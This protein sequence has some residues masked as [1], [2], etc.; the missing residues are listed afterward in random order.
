[1]EIRKIIEK[2]E[3]VKVAVYGDFCLD[4]YW[5]LDPK[6]SE[7]SVETGLR[8]DSV[9]S[10]NHMLGGAS[11]IV[12]NLA[13]MN[14]R[15]IKVVGAIGD[16]IFGKEINRQFIDLGVDIKFLTVQKDNF[17][18]CTYVKIYLHDKELPRIDFG[19]NNIRTLETDKII[20]AGIE[21]ALSSCDVFIFNQQILGS[22]TNYSFIKAVN[23][24]FKRY[25]N[26]IIISDTRHYGKQINHIIRKINEF[27]AAESA[28]I[29]IKPEENIHLKDL[30]KYG[31]KMYD[32]FKKPV[33]ITRGPKGMLVIDLKGFHQVPGINLM[34]KLD[35]VGAGD[36][37]ISALAL[38][39]GC[40]ENPRVAADFANLSAAVVVQKLFKAAIVS[41]GEIIAISKDI[42]YIYQP[43]LA[44]DERK[45]KFFNTSEIEICYS[46]KSIP[47]KKI[48]YA[49]FDNDGTISTLRQGW[50]T[51]MEKTMMKSIM[52]EKYLT[53]DKNIFNK[54]KQRI[55]SY[56]ESSTGIQT[57]LQM[58]ALVY[59]VK[60]FSIV[61][62]GKILDKFGYKEIYNLELMK[63][64]NKRI[65]KFRKGELNI[66]DL[67]IKGSINFLEAL[68]EKGVKLYLAS[69]TDYEDTLNE[70]K[71]LG[72]NDFFD[73]GIY[74]ALRDIS[75][76]SK[77]ILINKIINENNLMGS[78]LAVF[79]DG[80]VEIRECRKKEGLAVGI[81]SDEVR[82]YGSDPKKRTRLIKA[83][84][85]LVIPDFSQLSEILSF[86]F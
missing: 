48:K 9:N 55:S 68:R 52:G 2:I 49:V 33:F 15:N 3:K 21:E 24:L 57:I 28:D 14:P 10:C 17:N 36:T 18:T 79:G 72:Y 64:V 56:I 59:M 86:L 80:P 8:G 31:R 23:E 45:A 30:K 38:C 22:I 73:G 81:S 62:E 19:F 84:A 50:E 78:E 69:G 42:D 47:L 35:P 75:R 60:E 85:H 7:V 43:E 41:P 26:K 66:N 13:A 44:E 83:G 37:V 67:T 51:V 54:V 4:A 6:G 29:K 77:K 16:D 74:G 70:A 32:M 61:P 11:N 39:L 40:G 65:T 5:F 34:K 46:K 53:V 12:A 76:Y 27:E 1:M 82:R 58:E 63:T 71:I 20:L 25:S